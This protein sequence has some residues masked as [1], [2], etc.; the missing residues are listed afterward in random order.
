MADT[1]VGRVRAIAGHLRKLPD[2]TIELYIEDAK[3]EVAKLGVSSDRE[4]RM[5][6]YLAAHFGTLQNPRPTDQRV[7][8]LSLSYNRA[9]GDGLD[10]TEY[11][12]EYKRLLG[13]TSGILRVM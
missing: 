6:R 3:E 8:D 12:Q 1:T 9:S 11:G 4:E 5:Q 2:S 10:A 13:Q 7:K